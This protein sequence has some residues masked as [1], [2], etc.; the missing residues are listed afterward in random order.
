[1]ICFFL[2]K[3]DEVLYIKYVMKK[4]ILIPNFF[5]DMGGGRQ[6]NIQMRNDNLEGQISKLKQRMLCVKEVVT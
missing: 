5:V 6:R 1:M 3:F 2:S 4:E